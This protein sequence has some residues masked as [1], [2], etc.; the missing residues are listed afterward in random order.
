[1]KNSLILFILLIAFSYANAQ[2]EFLSSNITSDNNQLLKKDKI[3]IDFNTTYYEPFIEEFRQTESL[4]HLCIKNEPKKTVNLGNIEFIN[5][6]ELINISEEE[7]NPIFNSLKLSSRINKLSLTE[8][9]IEKFPYR[10]K[11]ISFNELSLKNCDGTK[12][13]NL[14][15][16]LDTENNIKKLRINNSQ[17]I[18]FKAKKLKNLQVLDLRNNQLSGIPYFLVELNNLDSLYISGNHIPDLINEVTK[19]ANSYLKFLEIDQIN[20]EELETIKGRL[21]GI[22]VKCKIAE[23]T[24]K[25]E[26]LNYGQLQASDKSIEI[27]SSA[28][29]AYPRMLSQNISNNTFDSTLFEER[30]WSER[31]LGKYP[32]SETSISE[33]VLNIYNYRSPV[34]RKMAFN[35]Y[36]KRN[37]L[38]FKTGV[39]SSELYKAYPELNSFKKMIWVI[40]DTMSRR[41]FYRQF[42]RMKFYDLRIQYNTSRQNFTLIFKAA[43]RFFK[44]NAYP[45]Y[46]NKSLETAQEKY[47]KIYAQYLKRLTQRARRFNK[48]IKR[49]K[50]KFSFAQENFKRML[51]NQLRDNYMSLEERK[52]TKKEWLAY[53]NEIVKNEKSVINDAKA[54]LNVLVRA[55][56]INNYLENSEIIGPES[57]PTRYY[58]QLT[59]KMDN[60]IPVQT[61]LIINKT[62]F[63][64]KIR[65][66]AN[67]LNPLT[68]FLEDEKSYAIVG[69]LPNKS[70]SI[71]TWDDISQ[72]ITIEENINIKRLASEVTSYSLATIGQIINTIEI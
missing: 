17:L 63:T 29:L 51:W 62:D 10:L 26:K 34:K 46:K 4:R 21:K 18:E 22:T 33:S 25:E 60:N 8:I 45:V 3:V 1:M 49:N 37:F 13:N 28:Y 7:F 36:K 16:Y 71:S 50:T 20:N 11:E 40:D 57:F 47:P 14:L 55:L 68:I 6:L 15:N 2:R 9:H 56:E 43:G 65:R 38:I 30:F 61:Y 54:R 52:M 44:V 59:D 12:I 66:V 58:F 39:V 48:E 53:Y 70:V 23:D 32:I 27:L 67:P 69:F 31:Y 35:F 5:K 64:Y 19:L 41:F 24:E 72:T 42:R